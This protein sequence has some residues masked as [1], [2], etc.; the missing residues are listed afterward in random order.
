[1]TLR[2]LLESEYAPL[3]ALKPKA[4]IQF[5]LTLDRYREVLGREPLLTDL[6]GIP[7][8]RFLTA[9]R[10]KVSIATTVKDRTHLVALWGYAAKRRLVDEFPALPRMKAPKRIPKAYRIEEVEK[11][12]QAARKS[13]MPVA[14]LPGSEFYSTLL[15]CCW[16]TAERIGAHMELRWSEVDLEERHV[17]FLAE[18]RK[19]ATRDIRRDLSPGLVQW[20]AAFRRGRKDSDL[21]WPWPRH[22]GS[23]WYEMKKIAAAAGVTNRGYHGFRKSHISYAEAKQAGAGQIAGD[24]SSPTITR[25]SY[26]D[27]TIAK[28][29]GTLDLLP[30]LGLDGEPPSPAADA[31]EDAMRAGHAAGK[32]LGASGLPQPSRAAVDALAASVGY[33]GDGAALFR[34]G[35]TLGFSAGSEPPADGGDRPAA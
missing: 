27:T 24:H 17:T 2:D 8:Q 28:Q 21:V 11:L 19:G 22:H 6:S 23:L 30:T 7:V 32:A 26:I 12:I 18:N 16:E 10:Q 14:G 9:R 29:K 25:D 5:R 34:Q 33:S 13:R 31:L 35:F 20:L 4:L 15:R 3:R 1:M